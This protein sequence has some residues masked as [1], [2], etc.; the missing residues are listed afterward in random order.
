[1]S[2]PNETA[3]SGVAVA[4]EP[5]TPA[6]GGWFAR[7]RVLAATGL[8]MMVHDKLRF[9]GT[10]LGVVFSVLIS[11]QPIGVLNGLLS[12]N[13]MFVDNAGA[14]IWV[15]PPDTDLVEAGT[16]LSESA[17]YRARVT[18]GVAEA[19]PLIFSNAR[20]Q[21]PAGGSESITLI[22]TD[23]AFDLGGPWN[24]VAGD[25]AAL[26]QPDTMLFE[27]SKRNAL[28]GLNLGSVREVNDRRVRAAGFTW[29]LEP[30]GPAYA[31]AEIG[32][33]RRL[34]DIPQDQTSFVLVRVAQGSDPAA[35]VEALRERLPELEVVTREMF[36]DTIVATLLREQLGVSFATSTVFG[37][38]IGFVVVALAMFSSVLERERELATLKAIGCT[39]GH[40]ALLVM[41]TAVAYGL[42]GS[43]VGLGLV[44]RV[45]DALRRPELV[46]II[47]DSLL[48][49]T[50]IVMIVLTLG[51]SLLALTRV[52]R[53]EPGIVFR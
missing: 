36:H 7:L 19:A 4:D 35:V 21:T 22:G 30:F 45:A 40:L 53:L 49:L 37:L 2:L 44:T 28:G 32:L 46:I 25:A 9:A 1:M 15:V 12:R 29:G 42:V 14:D 47:P 48:L 10:V 5:V 23:L 41:V 50:P 52:W 31:F 16:L 13:T 6:S 38:L 33:A 26:A 39:N 51:A 3:L 27:D 43:V 34:A 24:V 18:P 8:R 20:V 17:L 11:V